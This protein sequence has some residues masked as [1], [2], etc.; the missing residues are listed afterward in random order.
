MI[1]IKSKLKFVENIYNCII[2]NI[3]IFIS[4]YQMLL[5]FMNILYENLKLSF[6]I[7]QIISNIN[8]QTKIVVINNDLYQ[9]YTNFTLIIMIEILYS[10][11][12][13][14]K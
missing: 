6:A 7:V 1:V 12:F 5:K 8:F 10:F 3:P 9:L 2:F 14:I 4:K 11:V 13:V